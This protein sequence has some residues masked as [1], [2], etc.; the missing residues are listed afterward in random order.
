MSDL[1]Q[2]RDKAMDGEAIRVSHQELHLLATRLEPDTSAEI[3][4]TSQR[5][6]KMHGVLNGNGGLQRCSYSILL[7][8]TATDGRLRSECRFVG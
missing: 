8:V 4:V 1:R 3:L 5:L 6:R 7:F 2:V